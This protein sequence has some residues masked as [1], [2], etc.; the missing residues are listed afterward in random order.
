VAFGPDGKRVV[1]GGGDKTVK[2]WD[3]K[4]SKKADK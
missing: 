1:S 3:V 2:L 4:A